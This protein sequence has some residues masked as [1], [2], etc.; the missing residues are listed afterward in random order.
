MTWTSRFRLLLTAFLAA[1]L[2]LSSLGSVPAQA[3]PAPSAATVA[4]PPGWTLVPSSRGPEL[5][6][7]SPERLP[8]GDAMLEVRLEGRP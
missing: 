7:Q 3:A 8:W 4:L 1:G 5:N 6:W 2:A